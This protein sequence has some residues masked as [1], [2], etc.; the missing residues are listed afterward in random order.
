MDMI[1]ALVK[2]LEENQVVE[3]ALRPFI[4]RVQIPVKDYAG[5]GI[6]PYPS[7]YKGYSAMRFYSREKGGCGCL[8]GDIEVMDKDG[9]CVPVEGFDDS[10]HPVTELCESEIKKVPSGKWAAVCSHKTRG[11]S[12]DR[13]YTTQFDE[14]FKVLPKEIGFVVLD[15]IAM[16]PRP[17]LNVTLDAMH[18]E[19]YN[20]VGA[21]DL[22]WSEDMLPEIMAG[23]KKRFGSFVRN[24]DLYGQG[25]AE[26][27]LAKT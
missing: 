7:N 16:P 3:D 17:V 15:Y 19:I 2:K 10:P 24:P 6:I 25:A 13:P 14:G 20:P 27:E 11:P 22:L 1:N 26:K 5:G 8:C 4:K 9:S 23:L 12:I 21:V 18:N